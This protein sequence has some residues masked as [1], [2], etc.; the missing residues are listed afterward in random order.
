MKKKINSKNACRFVNGPQFSSITKRQHRR[1][2]FYVKE[3]A[4]LFFCPFFDINDC[5]ISFFSLSLIV[6]FFNFSQFFYSFQKCVF[7]CTSLCE[8]LATNSIEFASICEK[9]ATVRFSYYHHLPP[10]TFANTKFLMFACDRTQTQLQQKFI[11]S[12]KKGF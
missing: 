7:I 6:F 8:F 2:S 9:C 4:N 5:W 3:C 1:Y 12:G 11:Y 10:R